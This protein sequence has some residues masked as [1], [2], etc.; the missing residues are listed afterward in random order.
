MNR[1][2][3]LCC[4]SIWALSLFLARVNFVEATAKSVD[5]GDDDEISDF[6][7]EENPDYI[8]DND[9][10][11]DSGS[12]SENEEYDDDDENDEHENENEDSKNKVSKA[13]KKTKKTT[14]KAIKVLKKNR[15]TITLALVVFAFRN[16]IFLLI[17]KMLIRRT[18]TITDIFKLILFVDF[19]RRMQQSGGGGEGLSSSS[20]NANNFFDILKKIGQVNPILSAIIDKALCHNPAYIPPINQHYTFERLNEY[21]V[22]DGMALKKA[23]ETK[24]AEGLRW[25]TSSSLSPSSS[26]S[27]SII[28]PNFASSKKKATSGNKDIIK[29]TSSNNETV[30]IL[31]W[32]ELDTVVSSMED[33]RQQISFLLSEYRTLAMQQEDGENENTT[34]SKVDDNI[35]SITTNINNDDESTSIPALLEVVVHLESPGGSVSD[36]GLLGSHLLRLKKEPGVTL[37]ICVDKVA[38]SGGYM[39]CCTASP[40]KL[41]AA[42]FAMV[43]SIGVIATQINV[44]K[45]LNDYGIETLMFRGGKDKAPISLIGEVT[46]EGKR[47]TQLMIDDT[48]RA[49]KRHVVKARPVLEQNI[50]TIANGNVWLG[51]DALELNLIDA[52]KTSDEYIEEKIRDGAQVFKMIK[53]NVRSSFLFGPTL[54]GNPYYKSNKGLNINNNAAT[55]STSLEDDV[56]D[57]MQKKGITT[58]TRLPNSVKSIFSKTLKYFH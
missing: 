4:L 39:L 51:V 15:T 21:Y 38:A 14:S 19:M 55:S 40:G 23:I 29:S 32:T 18:L 34:N 56:Q 50:D 17:K 3:S 1:F 53:T 37:T 7:I 31:D 16:E 35:N 22:K 45:I 5:G 24:H 33:L 20:T 26:G 28:S 49:F 43:G 44:H 12:D 46:K 48:H 25:P 36:Y 11:S 52:I 30:V 42:P 8:S 27:S 58:M 9:S 54:G 2:L 13:L 10:G 47:T 57:L 6:L 41:F